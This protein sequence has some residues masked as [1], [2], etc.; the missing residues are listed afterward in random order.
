VIAEGRSVHEYLW[1]NRVSVY[2]GLPTILGWR[3]HQVQQRSLLP[4]EVIERRA[5]DVDALYRNPEPQTAERILERYGVE[6]VYVG[7][8]ERAYYP[9]TGLLKFERMVERGAL[10]IAYR[11]P[12]VVIYRVRPSVGVAD[13]QI[14][15]LISVR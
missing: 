13:R 5:R 12:E 8:L 11:N 3:N 1:G 14:P 6:M 2:T 4:V 7:P 15:L 9:E 10:E